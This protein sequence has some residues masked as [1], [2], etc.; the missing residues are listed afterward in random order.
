MSLMF[1]SETAPVSSMKHMIEVISLNIHRSSN[2]ASD[3]PRDDHHHE[4]H[5][6]DSKP[7]AGRIVVARHPGSKRK[8]TRDET[9][10]ERNPGHQDADLILS[11]LVFHD[12]DGF[13]TR[14]RN[15]IWRSSSIAN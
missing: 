2:G 3:K 7:R 14:M 10:E 11:K 15:W 5:S 6:L 8:E 13:R 1:R 12:D 9:R 4:A